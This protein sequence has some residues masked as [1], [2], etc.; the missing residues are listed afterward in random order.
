MPPEP[1][2]T[3]SAVARAALRRWSGPARRP[4]FLGLVYQLAGLL[5][6]VL[7]AI[8]IGQAVGAAALGAAPENGLLVAAAGM[9]LRTAGNW[10]A[11]FAYQ[12][13]G[14]LM[15]GR[16]RRELLETVPR[17]GA[18]WLGG[19]AS[20]A[21]VTQI[22]DRSAKLGGYAA[23]WLP[24][25]YMALAGPV[26]ILVV[27]GLHTWVAAAL[28]F[29]SV[30][31]LPLFL[32]LTASEAAA[33]AGAQQTSLDQLSGAFQ[34][35]AAQSGLIRAFR[36]IGRETR[37]LEAAAEDLRVRTMAILRVAFLSTA[38]IEFFASVSI[39]LVAVYIGFKLLDVF[40]F[41]TGET[42]SLAEGLTAL[43]LAPEYFAPIRRLSSLHH[44]RSAA[45]AAAG[46]LG[47]WLARAKTNSITRLARRQRPPVIEFDEA[48]LGWSDNVAIRPL[49]FV[50]R[51]GE[52]VALAGASGSGKSTILLA[53]LGQARQLGGVIRVDG[54]VLAP[55]QSLSE[56]VAHIGQ[57][58]WL[59]D[60]SLR[61]NIAI[62]RPEASPTEVEQAARE[63]GVMDFANEARGGLEQT[64][65]RFGVGLSGGQRQRIAFARAILRDAPVWLLDE[66]TAHLDPDAERVFVAQLKALSGDRTVIVATHSLLL[67]EA[68]D[69]VVAVRA[70]GA[71]LTA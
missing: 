52:I 33:L 68:A 62:A 67:T 12:R 61:E 4:V 43:L 5:G 39:A 31:V 51:P 40:P 1:D 59:M 19:A 2:Q 57:T 42:I 63:A 30:L 20:G 14:S 35:R 22:V 10:L 8:G 36:A 53:L 26:I 69:R 29:V 38:V 46:H 16:A 70:A 65:A 9:V 23:R 50:A 48:A 18:G 34:T 54:D 55:G 37:T 17:A 71:E 60:R 44:D 13:A 21:R 7:V 32:W 24:G 56:S 3:D 64:L 49:S 66:P 28:L 6:W 45:T 47:A 41:E 25:I 27:V 15:V 11:E 58:P